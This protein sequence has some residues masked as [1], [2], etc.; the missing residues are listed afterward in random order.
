MKKYREPSPITLSRLRAAG[1]CIGAK[2]EFAGLFPDGVVPTV[3][4][5][6]RHWA[7]FPMQWAAQVFL[8]EEGRDRYTKRVRKA[9]D[10]FD[11]T[12]HVYPGHNVPGAGAFYNARSHMWRTEAMVFVTLYQRYGKPYRPRKRVAITVDAPAPI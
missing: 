3:E 6:L 12:R 1:A 4:H 8:T 10:R 9:R 11:A 2:L 5:A 7:K